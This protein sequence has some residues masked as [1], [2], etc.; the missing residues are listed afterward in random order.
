MEK[1]IYTGHK[2][3]VYI[4]AIN[5]SVKQGE[6]IEVASAIATSLKLQGCFTNPKES[7][8]SSK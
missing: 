4:P 1:L 2:V 6:V 3:E 7:K 5:R 8:K